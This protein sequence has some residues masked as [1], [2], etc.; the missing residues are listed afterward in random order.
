MFKA[1]R[2]LY[3]STLG[4]RDTKTKRKDN[5]EYGEE[6]EQG[7]YCG[8]EDGDQVQPVPAQVNSPTS[9]VNLQNT[10]PEWV[11]K[12]LQFYFFLTTLEPSVK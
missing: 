10:C 8:E 4:S 9:P 6:V 3:H 11:P 1:H 12:G 7:S 5:S 2:L